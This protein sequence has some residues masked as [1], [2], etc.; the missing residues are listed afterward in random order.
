[1]SW[2]W[3][4]PLVWGDVCTFAG[5]AEQDV[6]PAERLH[7]LGDGGLTLRDPP[8]RGSATLFHAKDAP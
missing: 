2:A 4:V 7:G 8:A 6:Y 1:M 5:T 3:R